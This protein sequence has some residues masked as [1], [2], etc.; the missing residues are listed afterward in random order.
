[1]IWAGD[2]DNENF[3]LLGGVNLWRSFNGGGYLVWRLGGHVKIRVT[4][5]SGVNAVVSAIFF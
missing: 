1:M 4:S 5:L 3:L 2:A